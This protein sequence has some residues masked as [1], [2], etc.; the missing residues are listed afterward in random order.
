[1]LPTESPIAACR[2]AYRS[3]HSRADVSTLDRYATAWRTRVSGGGR[4]LVERTA[5]IVTLIGIPLEYDT[6]GDPISELKWSRWNLQ[7]RSPWRRAGPSLRPVRR[8][9]ARHSPAR[10][11]TARFRWTPPE[12]RWNY[13][14]RRSPAAPGRSSRRPRTA[15][16]S[17]P[18]THDPARPRTVC[19]LQGQ[20]G[21]ASR[22]AFTGLEAAG[23]Y[24]LGMAVAY[25]FG[26]TQF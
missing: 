19:G 15:D 18:S 20:H 2:V 23:V 13:S 21:L 7:T 14:R 11:R 3:G 12:R 6:A 10:W 25:D 8:G 22:P 16:A 4:K 26:S 17:P 5:D 24:N 9:V 1:C